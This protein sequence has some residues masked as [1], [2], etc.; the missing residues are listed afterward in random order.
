[1][2][3]KVLMSGRFE[4]F[5]T[6]YDHCRRELIQEFGPEEGAQ[7]LKELSLLSAL[8]MWRLRSIN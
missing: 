1:M 7:R 3:R 5:Q 8:I 6:M 4:A 2:T